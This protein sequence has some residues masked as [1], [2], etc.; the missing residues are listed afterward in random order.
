VSRP[1]AAAI[2]ISVAPFSSHTGI[3]A[4]PRDNRPFI[5]GCRAA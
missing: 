5:I 2:R 3:L 1:S 4:D